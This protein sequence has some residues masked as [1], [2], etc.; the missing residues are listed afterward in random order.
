MKRG[1]RLGAAVWLAAAAWVL[2][3]P[4]G[5]AAQEVP[6][7]FYG[8]VQVDGAYVPDG[9]VITAQ[10][11]GAGLWATETFTYQG[12]SVYRLD[13]PPDNSQTPSKDGGIDGD[14]V[15]FS[16][17]FGGSNLPATLA[18]TW[19]EAAAQQVNLQA[20]PTGTSTP[21][22]TP[23]APATPTPDEETSGLAPGAWAGIAI[24]GV[25]LLAWVIWLILRRWSW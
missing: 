10:I 17:R 16:I 19:H 24:G 4:G 5:A 25:S 13:V 21:G 2:A 7:R 11:E 15:T 18:S 20:A 9:T 23:A 14:S 1:I 3:V 8:T 22:P 6:C 12:E